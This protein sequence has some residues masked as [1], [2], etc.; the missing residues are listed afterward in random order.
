MVFERKYPRLKGWYF[1][2]RFGMGVDLVVGEFTNR[3]VPSAQSIILRITLEELNWW[4]AQ[5]DT[6]KPPA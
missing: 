3:F 1:L 2:D 6:L 5:L 4:I